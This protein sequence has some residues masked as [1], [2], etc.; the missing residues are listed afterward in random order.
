L[1]YRHQNGKERSRQ[2]KLRKKNTF[3]KFNFSVSGKLTFALELFLEVTVL[4][5]TEICRDNTEM[6]DTRCS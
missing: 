3:S 1:K 4:K 2:R 5:H 6:A